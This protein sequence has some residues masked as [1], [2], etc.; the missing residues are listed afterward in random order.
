MEVVPA[1]PVGRPAT[2]EVRPA[3]Y[4]TP[5]AVAK[6]QAYLMAYKIANREH[7]KAYYKEWRLA[8]RDKMNQANREYKA[9]VAQAKRLAREAQ[10]TEAQQN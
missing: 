3:N 10:G 1:R 9:R 6:R 7:L 4:Y 8:N 2:R 5:E